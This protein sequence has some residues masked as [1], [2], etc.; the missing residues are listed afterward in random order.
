MIL[1]ISRIWMKF[2]VNL[3]F[4]VLYSLNTCLYN[5]VFYWCFLFVSKINILQYISYSTIVNHFSTTKK[6]TKT[7]FSF[8]FGSF[9]VLFHIRILSH[10][11][12]HHIYI[13]S[14]NYHHFIVSIHYE[15][16]IQQYNEHLLNKTW[17]KY[18]K[19]WKKKYLFY[20]S[21]LLHA[22]QQLIHHL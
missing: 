14:L 12:N 4:V 13:F 5:F 1:Y 6:N 9:L 20:H 18:Q 22:V 11:Y 16:D 10:L 2:I 21:M 3:L 8:F 15:N 19:K 7:R 17:K